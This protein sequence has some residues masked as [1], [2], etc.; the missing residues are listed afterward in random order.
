[1]ASLLKANLRQADR[2]TAVVTLVLAT[3]LASA[4]FAETKAETRKEYRFTVGRNAIISVD[5]QFGAIS[6]KPG[7]A[8]EV[9]VVATLKSNNVEV[10]Q[11]QTGN[12]VEIASHLLEG[13]DQQAGRV[14]Y[15]LLIPPDATLNL[16]SSS[17]PLLAEH[18]QGDLTLE[19]ADAVVN[20]RNVQNCHVHVRT[21]GG[22]ITL[23]DVANGHI[24]VASIS[25][26][27]RMKSVTG[28]LV[29]VVSGRGKIF[30]DGDFGSGGDYR[31]TTHTGDIEAIV[32][33]DVSADFRAHSVIG[34][35]RHDF[36]LQPQHSRFP[37]EAGRSFL[38]TSGKA[39]SKVVLRSFS[40]KIRLKQR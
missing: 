31:F 25:G 35:V 3:C 39:S 23:T 36:P 9:V 34:R 8:D 2:Q 19:G 28:T 10:D 5:T 21:M 12:R 22:P 32:P 6:V 20:I 18:L 14:D 33:A 17:G 27:V 15:E 16:H 29:Q 7:S 11:E 24:E 40:G 13:A 38:G 1:M 30:Y 37:V 4:A 26:D